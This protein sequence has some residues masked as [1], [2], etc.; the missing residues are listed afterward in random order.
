MTGTASVNSW[1]ETSADSVRAMSAHR[2]R[3]GPF[4]AGDLVQL[5]DHKGKM[6]TITMTPGQVFHT[7]RSQIR[8]DDLIGAQEGTVIDAGN[9]ASYIAMRPALEDFIL[10]MPRGAA[11][12]YP[13]DAGRILTLAD[14]HV[15]SRVLEAGVGSGA[16][17]CFLLGAVGSHGFVS[18]Y[19]RREDFA[20]IA[21]TNV[22]RW[23]GSTEL[24]WQVQVGDVAH[25]QSDLPFDA[26]VYDMVAP[27]DCLDTVLR[28]LRPGGMFVAYVT[29]TTQMSRLVESMRLTR[30]FREPRAEESMIRTWHLDGLAVR[31]D[32]RMIGHSGFLVSSRILAPGMVAPERRRRPAPGAYGA[33]YT[34]PTREVV[35]DTNSG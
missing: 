28:V 9:G 30:R 31:P 18:S 12:I 2:T 11:V 8:H 34:P 29:T 20:A 3:R 14:I 1:G 5:T 15:G 27:W 35:D 16:L 10:S 32:H 33:D 26:V 25:A 17:T 24:P 22:T 19:E 21:Q 23:F 6:H 4:T 7:H 13:K